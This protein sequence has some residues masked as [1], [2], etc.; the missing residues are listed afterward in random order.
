[1]C[2]L[3]DRPLAAESYEQLQQEQEE[4]ECLLLDSSCAANLSFPF[5][6]LAPIEGKPRFRINSS[7]SKSSQ[8]MLFYLSCAFTYRSCLEP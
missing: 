7:F 2:T 1:M 6:P 4:E 5:E 8:F 3:V